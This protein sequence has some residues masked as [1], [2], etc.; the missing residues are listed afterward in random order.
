MPYALARLGIAN[1]IVAHNTPQGNWQQPSETGN[2]DGTVKNG[3]P[4]SIIPAIVTI[5]GRSV[6]AEPHRA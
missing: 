4:P 3:P 5:D 6:G 2:S 1:T